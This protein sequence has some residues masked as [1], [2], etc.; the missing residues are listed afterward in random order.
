MH[1][2]L[3]FFDAERRQTHC[4]HM[5]CKDDRRAMALVELVSQRHEMEL[6]QGRRVVKGYKGKLIGL[7][8]NIPFPIQASFH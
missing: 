3:S 2:I 7:Q 1:Y 5:N 6:R 4:V 8:A